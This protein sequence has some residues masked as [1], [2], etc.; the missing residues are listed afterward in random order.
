MLYHNKNV[1]AYDSILKNNFK[2]MINPC[3]RSSFFIPNDFLFYFR[4]VLDVKKIT[5]LLQSSHAVSPVINILYL[6]GTLVITNE[7]MWLHYY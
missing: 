7:L 3:K 4:V 6:Y 5:K 1:Y 2:G